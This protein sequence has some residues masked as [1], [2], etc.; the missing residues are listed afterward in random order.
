MNYFIIPIKILETLSVL[1][2]ITL[3]IILFRA[4]TVMHLFKLRIRRSRIVLQMC[5]KFA[6][7]SEKPN[8]TVNCCLEAASVSD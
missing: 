2:I 1:N 7:L 6:F 5:K 4:L 3:N 8:P